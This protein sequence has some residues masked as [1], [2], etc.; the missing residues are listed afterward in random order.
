M[1]GLAGFLQPAGMMAA[2]AQ[3]LVGSLAAR[4]THRGPD[5]QGEWVDGAAGIALGHRRLAVLDLSP[6]GHQPMISVS[7][8]YIIVFNGEIYNHLD[9][10]KQLESRGSGCVWRGHSDTETLL[11]AIEHWGI[12][13]TLQ[14]AVGMFALALWDRQHR[15][16]TLA[17]DR[18][19][20]KPLYYG[21]QGDVFLFASELKAISAHPAFHRDVDR[22]ALTLYMKYGYIPAPASIYRNIFKLMPGTY[23]QLPAAV[24]RGQSPEIRPYWSLRE[25]VERSVA[26]PFAGGDADAVDALESTLMRAVSLQRIADVPL[27]AFLS[28][29]VDS[30][31]IV[32][33][34]QAGAHHAVKTFTISY[35]ESS[36]CEARFARSV[37]A[38]L[39]TDHTELQVSARDAMDVIP[40]LAILY[41]EPFGDSSAIPSFLISSLARRQVTVAL[42]GDGGDELF[43]G[44]TRYQRTAGIWRFM[45]RVPYAA[46][47]VAAKLIRARRGS[48]SESACDERAKRLALYLSA[49]TLEECYRAQLSRIPDAQSLVM[50]ASSVHSVTSVLGRDPDTDGAVGEMMSIDTSSYLPDDILAKVDRAS[51][52]V[53]LEV[54]VPML[55]H[56][57]LEFAWRLPSHMK[58]RGRQGKWVLKQLLRKYLPDSMIERPKMGFGIPVGAW[59]RGPL[60]EWS[61]DLLAED[62]LRAEGFLNPLSVRR[63]WRRHLSEG[64][65]ESDALWQILA[66][67]SWVA[68]A[69]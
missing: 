30:S 60:R 50:G 4:L 58:I 41:D 52:G 69:P 67:Q 1:C 54:R 45:R 40:R 38:H 49:T 25:T 32:A 65:G 11:S 21:W 22:G 62:R 13:R 42:S 7:G 33:L 8:R 24:S 68:D 9:I 66:F 44:Y 17:R 20:E 18:L 3:H 61:E 2:A 63:L 10:R 47:S 19:G 46:R 23:A 53:S 36:F 27:G 64:R 34:M 48:D 14:A 39:G 35:Q 59:L 5:D 43:G 56:R 15:T 29:G 12:A 31:T 57:V 51:M 6:A 28:G 55:D 37:A 26:N 16:L